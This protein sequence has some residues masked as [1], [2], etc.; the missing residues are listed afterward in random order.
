MPPRRYS[1]PA[2][3]RLLPD[4]PDIKV[5]LI[6]DQGLTDIV[7]ERYD[8]GVRLAERVAKDMTSVRVGPDMCMAVVGA[9]SYFSRRPPPTTPKDLATHD[10]INIRRTTLGGF[11]DWEFEKGGRQIKIRVDGKL[12]L[13]NASLVLKAAVAGF[14]LA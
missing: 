12:V 8:A 3:H 6:T 14:G 10:C 2:L 9:P 11:Y 7:A 1:R 13:N 4:Y 5:D